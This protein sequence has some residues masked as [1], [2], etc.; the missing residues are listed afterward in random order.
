MSLDGR[1]AIITGGGGGIGQAIAQRFAGEGARVAIAD[2]DERAGLAT[3]LR[4][5]AAGSPAV[6]VRTDVGDEASTRTLAKT[7]VEKFGAIDILIN[8]AAVFASIAMKEVEEIS[9]AEWDSVMAVNL[10]GPFLTAKAVLPQMKRQRRGKIVNISSTTVFSGGPSLSHYVASKAGLIGF[11]R[12]LAREAGRHGICVNA[13]AAG[14]TDTPAAAGVI[15]AS[16]FEAVIGLRSIGR[17]QGP[18]DLVGAV[19]FLCSDDSDFVTGQTIVVDGG[20]IFL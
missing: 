11:T 18:A 3:A 17:P 4:L 10:R 14:L 1:V 19:S 7:V 13:V 2:T 6:F 8:N 20:Q 16:R 12:S 5:E 15:P 9:T